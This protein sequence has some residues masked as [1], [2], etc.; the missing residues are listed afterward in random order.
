MAPAI[1]L[2]ETFLILNIFQDVTGMLER[3]LQ[4][5]AL[6]HE[7]PAISLRRGL[8][9]TR[10]MG[11]LIRQAKI[12]D[13]ILCRHN[14]HTRTQQH[15]RPEQTFKILL[16][17]STMVLHHPD[18]IRTQLPALGKRLQLP[19][20]IS[21]IQESILL[22]ALLE[23]TTPRSPTPD[24]KHRSEE[25]TVWTITGYLVLIESCNHRDT[26]IVLIPVEH[27]LTE[28]KERLRRHTVIFQ[29]DALINHRK[30]PFLRKMSRRVTSLIPGLIRTMHLALPIDILIRCYLPARLNARHIPFS[31]CSI[32]IEEQL[33]RTS[34]L[35]L[36]EN[37]L[38]MIWAIE[39]Q[40]QYSH[41][42]LS[43]LFHIYYL[44]TKLANSRNYILCKD[45]AKRRQCQIKLPQKQAKMQYFPFFLPTINFLH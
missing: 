31:P 4:F 19:H 20:G 28:R 23:N 39:K 9:A 10:K 12:I 38:E 6:H 41:I 34:L 40:H 7:N 15:G 29:D 18:K 24:S 21:I 13:Q 27:F 32:L 5:M 43:R 3:E 1:N 33:G 2:V 14:R 42:Y 25:I 36:V 16:A 35:H 37:F 22:I 17:R 11:R 44:F 45:N 26:F 8:H 30:S